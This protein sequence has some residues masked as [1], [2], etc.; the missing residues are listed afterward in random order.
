MPMFARTTVNANDE[1]LAWWRS[2]SLVGWGLL[3]MATVATVGLVFGLAF[4][5]TLLLPSFS[6]KNGP[7]ILSYARSPALFVLAMALN[8]VASLIIWGLF[9]RWLMNRRRL[10][11]NPI[12]HGKF[13]H[14]V[15]GTKYDPKTG[16]RD[17]LG[18]AGR[19]DASQ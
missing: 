1:P 3:F 18:D 13:A 10:P 9:V 15:R 7:A 4:G 5:E 17:A 12:Q 8:L 19:A 16:T 14:N 11:D 6:S 2:M